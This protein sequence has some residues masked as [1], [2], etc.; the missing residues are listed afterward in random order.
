MSPPEA[1]LKAPDKDR[2]ERG[3][4]SLQEVAATEDPQVLHDLAG[5]AARQASLLMTTY[6]AGPGPSY[7]PRI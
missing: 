3:L 5:V 2:Y 1:P 4:A 6:Q 7:F